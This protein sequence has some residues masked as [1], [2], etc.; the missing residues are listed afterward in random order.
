MFFKN[1]YNKRDDEKGYCV[2]EIPKASINEE[3]VSIQCDESR[4][5][6]CINNTCQCPVGQKWYNVKYLLSI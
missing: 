1:S 2:N 5:L 3:C 4:D 6:V